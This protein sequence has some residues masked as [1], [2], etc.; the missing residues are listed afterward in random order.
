MPKWWILCGTH[1]V[2]YY[3]RICITIT[4]AVSWT[5]F[6]ENPWGFLNV[7]HKDFI[8]IRSLEPVVW[9]E[10]RIFVLSVARNAFFI[11]LP[12]LLSSMDA[13]K[14]CSHRKW[15][16]FNWNTDSVAL[17]KLSS[18]E[19]F[20]RLFLWKEINIILSIFTDIFYQRNYLI[21]LLKCLCRT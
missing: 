15:A 2:H 17:G 16:S 20:S 14:I 21:N 6:H 10:H 3:K 7:F 9:I 8:W 1:P 18:T 11:P 13:L 12:A 19:T 4:S 5:W